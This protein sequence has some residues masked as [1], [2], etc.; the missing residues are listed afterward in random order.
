MT[1][2][3]HQP[4]EGSWV[5]LWRHFSISG[6]VRVVDDPGEMRESQKKLEE[7]FISKTV[8]NVTLFIRLDT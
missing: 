3:H 5:V 2:I 6:H 1:V 7:W 8:S 4:E